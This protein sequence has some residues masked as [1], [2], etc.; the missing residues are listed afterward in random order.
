MTACT[1]KL[2]AKARVQSYTRLHTC[3]IVTRYQDNAP[4]KFLRYRTLETLFLYRPHS[5]HM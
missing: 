1:C 5:I 2:C 3:Y 4:N